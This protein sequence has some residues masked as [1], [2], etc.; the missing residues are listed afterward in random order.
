[1]ARDYL[2]IQGSA[3]SSEHAFSNASLTDTKQ[4]RRLTPEMFEAL[5][6]LKSVYRNGHLCATEEAEKHY[7]AVMNAGGGAV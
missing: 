6:I 4:R 1:M 5:Q 7:Q 2:A 3:T